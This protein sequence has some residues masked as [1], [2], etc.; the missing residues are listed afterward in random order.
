M[1][2][3]EKK[4]ESDKV[5]KCKERNEFEWIEIFFILDR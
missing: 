4:E 5:T 3:R 2:E 1:K